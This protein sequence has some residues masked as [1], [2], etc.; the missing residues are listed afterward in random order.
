M[1]QFSKI[2]DTG[3]S[4][5]VMCLKNNDSAQSVRFSID[6]VQKSGK[7][8][9]GRVGSTCRNIFEDHMVCKIVYKTV[10]LC[11]KIDFESVDGCFFVL[12]ILLDR[13]HGQFVN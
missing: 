3:S 6:I 1:K 2:F 4:L 12:T 13:V 11:F 9:M 8:S 10:S 5:E 7:H